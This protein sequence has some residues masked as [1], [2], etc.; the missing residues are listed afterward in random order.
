MSDTDP[1]SSS[2]SG[3]ARGTAEPEPPPR[4]ATSHT[5]YASGRLLLVNP[6]APAQAIPDDFDFDEVVDLI[7]PGGH[8]VARKKP[9]GPA[10][11]YLFRMTDPRMKWFEAGAEAA[12]RAV[13]QTAQAARSTDSTTMVTIQKARV[14]HMHSAPAP[15]SDP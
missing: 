4:L 12:R 11:G 6:G 10:V 5:G 3:S 9:D 14:V 8:V 2:H 1:S 7:A 13:V 15:T